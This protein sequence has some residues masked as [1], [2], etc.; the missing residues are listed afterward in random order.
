M[1]DKAKKNLAGYKA[2]LLK[3]EL[4]ELDLEE[5][6]FDAI[7]CTEVLEHVVDPENVLRGIERLVRRDGRVVITFPND[8]LIEQ[9]KGMVI[10]M[11][12]SKLLRVEWGGDHFH[13][14]IWSIDEMRALLSKYFRV[15]DERFAPTRLMPVR[16]CFGCRPR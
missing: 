15:A 9:L 2:T 6:S 1:L 13:L 3:G 12:L 5:H 16:C 4:D 11:G 8:T 7:I 10:K 14:H